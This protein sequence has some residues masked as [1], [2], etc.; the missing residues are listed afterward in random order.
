VRSNIIKRT[1]IIIP[2]SCFLVVGNSREYIVMGI[3]NKVKIKI[4][5]RF[6]PMSPI[7]SGGRFRAVPIETENNKER[8][9]KKAETKKLIKLKTTNHPKFSHDDNPS[10][11]DKFLILF[12]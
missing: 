10:K 5:N 1:H 6:S 7:N 2:I 3:T 4:N 9:T 12:K 11:N 8:L